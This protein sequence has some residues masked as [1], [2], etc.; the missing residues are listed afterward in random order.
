MADTQRAPAAVVKALKESRHGRQWL[1]GVLLFV[2]SW[3]LASFICYG[4][5]ACG[6]GHWIE[7]FNGAT[8][9]P[10]FL[11]GA[12]EEA[13]TPIRTLPFYIV[14]GFRTV[15]NLGIVLSAAF[16]LYLLSTGQ[17]KEW[18]MSKLESVLSTRD[19]A[20]AAF[21]IHKM[22]EKID[23]TPEIRQKMFDAAGEFHETEAG[24]RFLK[25]FL[26]AVRTGQPMH[27]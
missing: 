21:L 27:D 6:S 7:L 1:V 4:L 23:V 12:A 9:P 11:P 5:I 19:A 13:H 3:V 18:L 22:K 17:L 14:L 20:L 16:V 24:R 10:Q 26:T 2:G 8:W 25:S 15:L